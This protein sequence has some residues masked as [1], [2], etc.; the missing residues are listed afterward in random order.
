MTAL[1]NKWRPIM[2]GGFA[3][4]IALPAIAMLAGGDVNWGPED[5]TFA[6]ILFGLLGGGVELT[7]RAKQVGAYRWAS[8][9]ALGLGF[10]TLWINLAVGIIGSDDNPLN[11][12]YIYVL[13]I[14]IVGSLVARFKPNGMALAMVAT[15]IAHLVIAGIAHTAGYN[16]WPFA[17]VFAFL[18]MVA[19]HLYRTA[20]KARS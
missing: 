12:H 8:I 17:I 2:W 11:G 15:A 6:I 9:I 13:G 1:M 3:A 19:A 5:F 16:I 18:H 14:P 7:M 20:A 10:L 4:L